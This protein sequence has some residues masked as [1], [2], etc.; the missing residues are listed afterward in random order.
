MGKKSIYRLKFLLVL[1]VLVTLTACDEF[2]QPTSYVVEFYKSTEPTSREINKVALFPMGK[3][4]TTDT[5]TFYS[6]NHF[7][8]RLEQKFPNVKFFIPS[9][10]KLTQKDSL[11]VPQLVKSIEL[12]N[13]LNLES[14]SSSDVGKLLSNDKPDAMIIGVINSS[15]T[16]RGVG[17]VRDE[18][19]HFQFRSITS[20][21]FT[22]YLISLKDGSIVWKVRVVGEEVNNSNHINDDYPPL[23]AAISNGID[24]IL[25]SGEAQTN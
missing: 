4:D 24:L 14:F 22:Y 17:L 13:K 2:I 25:D 9:I 21:D 8:N 11:F 10:E 5:G 23:D 19:L 15:S 7:I 3:D 12:A 18:F 6:T 16:R 20:C 1:S